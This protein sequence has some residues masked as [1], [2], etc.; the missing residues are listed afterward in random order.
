MES[1]QDLLRKDLHAREVN[2]ALRSL[3]SSDYNLLDFSSNDYLGLARSKELSSQIEQAWASTQNKYNGATG[4]RLLTGN[5]FIA[6][7][8]ERELANLFKGEAA[9]LFN[10]GYT[11]NLSVL[12]SLPKRGDT[13]LY[14]ELSHASIKDGM[15]LSLATR[16][17][18]S[19]NDLQDLEKKLTKAQGNIF[20]VVESIYSMDGDIAPLIGL[21]SLCEQYKAHLIIDEA[22]STGIYGSKGNGLSCVLNVD[23]KIPVRI[24]TFGKAMGLHGACVVGSKELVNYLINFAR[25]FIYTTAMDAKSILAI[26]EAFKFLSNRPILQQELQNRI[27][28][29]TAAMR[30]IPELVSSTSAI[31]SFI[32]PGNEQVKKIANQ[33]Q[34][35]GLDVRPI[36]SP[37]VPEGKE[38]LRIILHTF[39]TISEIDKLIFELHS[40]SSPS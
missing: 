36:L 32:V 27:N 14:D 30:D 1:F 11:A 34:M 19:H 22:H 7:D 6:E 9:L 10:S 16:L 28:Y 21:S 29:F 38:R 33:L 40:V 5:S 4:S 25:P 15:R 2:G 24:Y 20:V 23:Q 26:S 18:F 39:N 17:P 3:K 31:Q 13:I 8:V 35:A 12:S 37:T